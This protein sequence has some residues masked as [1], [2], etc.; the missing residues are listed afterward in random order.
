MQNGAVFFDM[1]GT[2]VDGREGILKPTERTKE[3]ILKLRDNHYLVGLATGRAKCYVPESALLFDCYV[4]SNGAY[5]EVENKAIN[6]SVIEQS[7]LMKLLAYLDN[8]KMNYVME[9]QECC[10]V[11]D[12]AEPYYLG[13]MK[14]FNLGD[15]NFYL[16]R[17][18]GPIDTANI[19]KLMVT[20]DSEEKLSQFIRDFGSCYDITRQP[21]NQACDVGKKGITKAFGTGQVIHFLGLDKSNTYA[22]GDADNDYDMFGTVGTGIAMARHTPKLGKAARYITDSVKED[23]IYHALIHFGLIK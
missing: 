21:G 11:K 10:Y 12:I 2:L 16:L 9:N 13:M 5:A 4:T 7:E 18:V 3:A 14:N 22:F 20:Y 19:N 1:D 17:D 6:N 15:K 8:A 23:G